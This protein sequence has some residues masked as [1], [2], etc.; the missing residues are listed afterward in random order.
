MKNYYH[1]ALEIEK[2]MGAQEM[3]SEK[4][5]ET[6]KRAPLRGLDL[7]GVVLSTACLIHCTILPLCLA[8]LPFLGSHFHLDEKWHFYMT[9]LIVPVACVALVTGWMRHRQ[10]LVIILGSVALAMILGAHPL[11]D[12]LGHWGAEIVGALGGC[13]LIGAHLFN[14]HYLH[15]TAGCCAACSSH[16]GEVAPKAA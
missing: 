9:A 5:V 16:S 15:Q 14:H 3:M 11:H 4:R 7:L 2:G 6:R 8:L 13:I 10:A 12:L 1:L